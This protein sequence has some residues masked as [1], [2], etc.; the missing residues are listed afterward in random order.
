M[1]KLKCGITVATLTLLALSGCSLILPVKETPAETPKPTATATVVPTPASSPHISA[2]AT[3]VPSPSKSPEPDRTPLPE[4]TQMFPDISYTFDSDEN[5]QPENVTLYVLEDA[6]DRPEI[7]LSVLSGAETYAANEG[8]FMSAYYMDFT[9]GQACVLL[10]MDAM[11]D[12]WWT[13]VYRLNGG[14]M[15]VM[16][17]QT[18]GYVERLDGWSVT[19]V[20][21]ID[22][23]G[24]YNAQ[25][26]YQIGDSLDLKPA[27]DGL[28]HMREND[29]FITCL[30]ELP[31]EF[32]ADNSYKPG[33]LEPGASSRFTSTDNETMVYF[34]GQD[35]SEGRLQFTREGGSLSINGMEDWDCF[36]SLPYAG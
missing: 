5:G 9:G 4:V 6:G 7:Q 10:S 17:D 23:L 19:M 11:S 31:V 30:V 8:W 22:V 25:C 13:A 32:R 14:T 26:E 29:E 24:T 34:E 12:D 16:T 2:T 21:N 36:E 1:R 27:G 18:S 33:I 35:G 15:P 20:D 28:W 3:T